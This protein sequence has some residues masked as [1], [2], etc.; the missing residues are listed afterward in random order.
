MKNLLSELNIFNTFYASK[1]K[2][3]LKNYFEKK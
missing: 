2:A 3:P 1:I